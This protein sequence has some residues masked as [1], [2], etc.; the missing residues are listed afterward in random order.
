[1][2]SVL[3]TCCSKSWNSGK[4]CT[5]YYNFIVAKEYKSEPAKRKDRAE[6]GTWR[7]PD[8]KPS[9]SPWV[10]YPPSVNEW[11]YVRGYC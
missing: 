3:I 1:M 11:Q 5:C 6:S 10:H 4:H 8:V 7:V 9:V 2:P